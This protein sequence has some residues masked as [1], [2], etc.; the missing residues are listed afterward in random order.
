[1]WHTG[2][3]NGIVRISACQGSEH[4][5]MIKGNPREFFGSDGIILELDHSGD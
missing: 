5:V 4:A 3:D 1:M 2:K